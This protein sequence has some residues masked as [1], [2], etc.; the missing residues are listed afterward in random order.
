M[1]DVACPERPANFD[2]I[3][4]GR[5]DYEHRNSGLTITYIDDLEGPKRPEIL[6]DSY[7]QVT[8]HIKSNPN[9]IRGGPPTGQPGKSIPRSVVESHNTCR[10]QRVQ[11]AFLP[12]KARNAP[13]HLI[14]SARFAEETE[15]LLCKLLVLPKA[16]DRA[17][18]D[19]DERV[20][21]IG[22]ADALRDDVGGTH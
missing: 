19:Q 21:K 3:G 15:Q 9:R 16:N 4:D 7:F 6:P 10:P 22:L 8:R 1:A 20:L 13:R 11:E 5:S 17:S 14:E 18:Q 12:A 2:S